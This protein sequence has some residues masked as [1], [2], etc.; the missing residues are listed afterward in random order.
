[1]GYYQNQQSE[2]RE[3]RHE[4]QIVAQER[5]QAEE[6]GNVLEVGGSSSQPFNIED[7]FQSVMSKL[8]SIELEQ[9]QLREFVT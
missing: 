7:A 9:A 1:M 5:G 2:K 6:K 3:K 4:E 8:T